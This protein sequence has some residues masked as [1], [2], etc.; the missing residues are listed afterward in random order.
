VFTEVLAAARRRSDALVRKDIETLL[1]L[2]HPDCLYI[3]SRGAVFGR[4][5]YLD[6]YVRADDVRWSSQTL[7]Q[8]RFASAG[9]TTVLTCLVHDVGTF[10]GQALDDSFRSTSTWISTENGWQCL[11][12]HTAQAE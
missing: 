2:M 5:E 8:P 3:S 7:R 6:T 4:D 10:F 12:I 9:E 11:A 1:A